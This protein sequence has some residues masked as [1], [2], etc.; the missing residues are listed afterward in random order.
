MKTAFNRCD[1]DED[2][3]MT[4][5]DMELLADRSIEMER[6]EGEEATATREK[7]LMLFKEYLNANEQPANLDDFLTK[8]KIAGKER[9]RQSCLMFFPNYFTAMDT[10]QDDM[11]SSEDYYAFSKLYGITE[12]HSNESFNHMDVDQDGKISKQEFIEAAERF[13]LLEVEGDPSQYLFGPLA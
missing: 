12:R 1:T 4:L 10:D 11:I 6:L 3:L 7:Y 2:G 13:Y 5:K 9:I 8:L